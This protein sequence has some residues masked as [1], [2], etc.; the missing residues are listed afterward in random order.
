MCSCSFR[1]QLNCT[2]PGLTASELELWTRGDGGREGQWSEE[3]LKNNNKHRHT[4][5]YDELI[6][7]FATQEQKKQVAVVSYLEP[8]DVKSPHTSEEGWAAGMEDPKSKKA[9]GT[10]EKQLCVH[11]QH[12]NSVYFMI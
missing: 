9:S 12:G 11:I 1:A 2:H 4:F 8:A 3:E 5:I 7:W 10:A 6:R